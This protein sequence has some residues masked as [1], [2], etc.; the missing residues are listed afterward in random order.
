MTFKII[1]Q[2]ADALSLSSWLKDGACVEMRTEPDA[3]GR[4][5]FV[6]C[7]GWLTEDEYNRQLHWTPAKRPVV[8]GI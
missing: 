4:Y 5:H 6:S 2:D 8:G 3:L 7:Q 1:I